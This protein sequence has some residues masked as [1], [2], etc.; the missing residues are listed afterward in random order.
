MTG[1]FMADDT[2]QENALN[3]TEYQM[4]VAP[5]LKVAAE[6]AARRGDPTL[7]ADLPVMLAL[8]YLVTGLAGFYRE[9]W[10]DLSG[11]T[12]EK[13]LKSAPMAACVMVLKQAGLDE[14]STNQ[15][16]QA[17]QG[18]YQQTLDAE[19]GW[20]AEGHIE[21]AWRHMTNDKRDLAL[22]SLNSAAEQLVAAIEI[23]ES[24]RSAKH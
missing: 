6:L 5:S 11:G 24:S 2:L 19:L 20:T 10:A 17:L 9:E 22:A 12:N 13:A 3:S 21:T 23:W 4:I 7:Q 8:I 14:V 16:Q 15:C 18:A 1:F